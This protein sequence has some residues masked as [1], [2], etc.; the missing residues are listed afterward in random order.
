M[1]LWRGTSLVLERSKLYMRG[2][3]LR[4]PVTLKTVATTRSRGA[5]MDWCRRNGYS[6]MNPIPNIDQVAL[7]ERI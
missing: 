7:E 1:Y 4:H 5:A 3:V 2:M 6:W